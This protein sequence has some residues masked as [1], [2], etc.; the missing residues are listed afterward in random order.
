M[1]KLYYLVVE[2]APDVCE[3][4]IRRMKNF[5]K[6]ESLGYCVGVKEAIEKIASDKP[7]LL[8]LDWSLNGGGAFEILQFIQNDTTYHPYIIFNTGFQKDNPEIPQEIINH[9]KV[10]KYLIKPLWENL[11]NNLATYVLEAEEKSKA[12]NQTKYI[13]W[14]EDEHKQTIA[15]DFNKLICI[16]QHPEKPRTRSLYLQG[17]TQ[18]VNV[19]MQWYKC[20]EL[21]NK[22]KVE[23][24]ITKN[25][26][27]LVVKQFIEKYEKPYVRLKGFAFK[28][29][30]VKENTSRLVEWLKN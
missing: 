12:S 27:H 10:D 15:V 4:I 9:Y 23:Y 7:Q 14:L 29:E 6:W 2:N 25:R 11:R 26:E 30:V 24:F 8:F 16:C 19:A 3:G 28:I 21:L 18:P 1:D 5:D 13:C 17:S 20:Y 22:F